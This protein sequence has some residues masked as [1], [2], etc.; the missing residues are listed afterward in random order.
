MVP[1]V[2]IEPHRTLNIKMEHTF[3]QRRQPGAGKNSFPGCLSLEEQHLYKPS[4]LERQW[5]W[6]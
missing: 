5:K 2:K 6:G 1:I 4:K 3:A